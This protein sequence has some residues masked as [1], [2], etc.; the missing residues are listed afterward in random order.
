MSEAFRVL[1]PG[2]LLYIGTPNCM[3]WGF[4]ILRGRWHALQ[5]PYHLVLLH[6]DALCAIGEGAGF[7]RFSLRSVS[8]PSSGMRAS[9]QTTARLDGTV[10]ERL[11]MSLYSVV[12]VVLGL[13][14]VRNQRFM[15]SFGMSFRKPL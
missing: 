15:E 3:A 2:G 13:I 10:G 11:L 9:R 5:P 12:G 1:A 14:H 4:S 7:Q 6:L 8:T